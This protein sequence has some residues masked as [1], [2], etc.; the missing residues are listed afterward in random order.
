MVPRNP[1]ALIHE[2][3]RLTIAQF[4][5]PEFRQLLSLPITL[6]RAQCYVLHRAHFQ[7]NRRTVWPYVQAAVPLD[8]KRMIWDHER[9]ELDYDPRAGTNHIILGNREC[10]AV[11]LNVAEIEAAELVP[12]ASAC[13]WAWIHLAITRPWLEAFTASSM[14]ER[15]NSGQVIPAGGLSE[16]MGRNIAQGLGIP[17][18]RLVNSS[19]HMEADVEHSTMLDFVAERYATTDEAR[20]AMLRGARD[21]FIIDRAFR[22][23]IAEAMEDLP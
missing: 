1:V 21:S 18:E 22:G 20:Q 19:V 11:G 3:D 2:L 7:R 12:A 6:A 9:E 14:M 15:M 8:L 4:E 5:T 10:E 17:L 16:Q 13:F 23:A